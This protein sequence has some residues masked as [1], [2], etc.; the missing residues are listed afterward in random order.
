MIMA[1][2]E[3]IATPGAEVALSAAVAKTVLQILA[4]TNQRV[5][6]LAFGIFFDGSVP[7]A[8]PVV[9][10]LVRQT[11]AGSGMATVTMVKTGPVAGSETLQTQGFHTATS[12][13][14]TTDIL[15]I[16]EIHPQAGV[17]KLFPLGREIVIAGGTRLGLVVTSPSAL[18][19]IPKIFG[20]E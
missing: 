7:N 14:T 3:F 1:A 4:P 20:E 15:D 12:E 10:K 16:F 13:P 11:T 5:R 9:V 19:C 17:E 2:I 18:N 8:E 6:I